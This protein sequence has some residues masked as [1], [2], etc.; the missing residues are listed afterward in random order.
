MEKSQEGES[1][2][3]EVVRCFLS[4]PRGAEFESVRAIVAEVLQENGIEPMSPGEVA[5][6]GVVVR[7]IQLAIDVADFVIADLTG[8][9]PNVMYEVGFA[10]AKR[11]PIVSL[12]RQGSKKI[13]SNV[14][15]IVIIIYIPSER[16]DLRRDLTSAVRYVRD[17]VAGTR[18][19]GR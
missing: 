8:A 4:V 5:E 9:N 12:V 10:E 13:P 19:L 15:G 3:S 7:G 16:E 11:K 17:R 2:L 1:E 18:P 6:P 14:H